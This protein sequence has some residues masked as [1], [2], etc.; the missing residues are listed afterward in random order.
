MDKNK[1]YSILG[2]LLASS[3]IYF[4]AEFIP[5]LN[6]VMLGLLI[7]ILIGNVVK[8]P[9]NV[10]GGLKYA[11]SKLLE[12]SI[13]MLAFGISASSL[14]AMGVPFLIKILI[15]VLLVLTTAILLN[16]MLRCDGTTGLLTGFGTAICGSSAI[17]AVAPVISDDKEDAGIAIAVVNLLGA[18]GTFLLP[19][20]LSYIDLEDVQKG[21]L[22]G[23]SLH[24]VGNVAGAGYAI[25]DSIG[26]T[27]VAVK[28]VRVALLSPMV[29]FYSYFVNKGKG[30]G[31]KTSFKLPI[32]LWLFI[33]I[34]VLTFFV[35]LPEELVKYLKMVGKIF[36]TAAML[37][38]GLR[39]SLK[40]LFLSGRVAFLYGIILFIAQLIIFTVLMLL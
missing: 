3:G 14:A 26:E 7:G 29:I 27:A 33:G 10:N 15:G 39:L 21:F 9:Q 23:G 38:I 12:V 1:A 11:G 16:R 22:I 8:I 31:S 34:T 25:S 18:L 24:A 28:M 17:A 40:R 4:L 35:E 32:Y 13:V 5:I 19:A 37:A 6:S 30:D 20:V 2:V 36:L